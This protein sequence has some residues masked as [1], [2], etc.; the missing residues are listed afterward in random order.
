MVDILG[1]VWRLSS[2]QAAALWPSLTGLP[3]TAF[4]NGPA[5]HAI[6]GLSGTVSNYCEAIT[7]L[8]EHYDRPGLLHQAHVCTIVEAPSLKDGSGKELCGLYDV[9]AQHLWALKVMVYKPGT[10]ITSPIDM[11]MD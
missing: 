8:Q 11:K 9:L 7:L 10:F 3:P 6:E 5:R 2:Q 4:K 1:T